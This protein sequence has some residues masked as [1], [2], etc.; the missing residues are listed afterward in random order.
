[1]TEAY[2]GMGANLGEPRAQLL[3][4][5]DALGRISDTR[6]IARSSLYRS[7]PIGYE[8]QPAFLN[9]VAKLET[10]LP[11]HALLAQ[12]QQIERDLGRVRSFRN[13]PR[14]IDLDL[15]LYGSETMD[16]PGLTLP[17]P[18][19]HERA[20]VLVPLLELDAGAMIP[21][22]GKAAELLRE[23][24]AGQPVERVEV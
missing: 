11:A 17:H 16:T 6:A 9:C 4:A 8:D 12:L 24:C 22:R 13:A 14:T 20:F 23:E 3:A 19:M 21:G 18:R 7:A 5:W 1:M 15:L 2:V 10:A